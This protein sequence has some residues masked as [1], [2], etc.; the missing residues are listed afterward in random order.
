VTGTPAILATKVPSWTAPNLGATLLLTPLGLPAKLLSL[1]IDKKRSSWIHAS[2]DEASYR[3]SAVPEPSH[4]RL[5]V[6]R[7][8]AGGLPL[9]IVVPAPTMTGLIIK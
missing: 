8:E 4:V 3:T 1:E 6:S 5:L 7:S 2:S 9:K